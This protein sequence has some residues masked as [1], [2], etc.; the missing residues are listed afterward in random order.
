MVAQNLLSLSVQAD[1]NMISILNK[2][3]IIICKEDAVYITLSKPPVIT[4]QR[5]SNGLWKVPIVPQSAPHI[6]LDTYYHPKIAN[7]AIPTFNNKS[8]WNIPLPTAAWLR[9][10]EQPVYCALSAY[11]KPLLEALAI[12]LHA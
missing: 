4:R 1:N 2:K 12:Y 8:L 3:K 11:S 6:N 10:E 9:Q 7:S 5:A